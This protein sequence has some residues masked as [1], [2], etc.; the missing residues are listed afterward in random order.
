MEIRPVTPQD[1]SDDIQRLYNI[2]LHAYKVTEVE[3]WGE[4]YKR[5]LPDEFSAIIEK[6]ELIGAWVENDPV[7]S[8]HTYPLNNNTYAF[9]LFSVDFDYKG[10]NI[11]RALIKAAEEKAKSN[12]AEF[13]EL[14]IL[15]LKNK[16]LEAKQRLHHWYLRLGYQHISTT[17]FIER[18]PTKAEKAKNFI[19]PSVFDCYRKVLK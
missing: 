19:A 13:M 3:I 7:G 10:M 8:I 11:G 2:M 1:A 4:D 6:G 16:E 15:R 12:G 18:K 5:M 9:G 17:D 14:E